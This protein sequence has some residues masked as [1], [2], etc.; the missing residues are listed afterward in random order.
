MIVC[1]VAGITKVTDKNRDDV[2]LFMMA[3][4]ELMSR[5]NGDGLGYAAFDKSGKIFGERWLMNKTAF[6]D[7]SGVRNLTAEKMNKIYN[8]FGD[9]VL[10]DEAQAIILHT[11]AATCGRGILNTHPFINDIDKPTSA[12]IHNGIIANHD[13]LV[14]K[15]SSC[16]SEVIVHLYEE[17]KVAAKFENIR[18]VMQ[19]LLGW[20]TV[21][22][23]ATDET[24]R[25]VMDIFSDAPRLAGFFIPELDTR[26]Y[27]T[28]ADDIV[29]AA[30]SL[31]MTYKEPFVIKANTAFRVD[32]LTGQVID[33]VKGA[34]YSY[35]Q[36]LRDSGVVL[37]EG[38][39]DDAE[40][41][42]AFFGRS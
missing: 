10:R 22:C 19:G 24:N 42:E 5:G 14:K 31:G 12:I 21:A 28:Q 8:Y 39:F 32:V 25:M 11:R 35:E 34:E 2:W 30:E 7:M 33:K 15:Y 3:L 17:M 16:D 23:L 9:K 40:F 4:G 18:E 38:N 1:K 36:F 20:F 13:A 29:R 41:R 37:E 27:S 6:T 26:I